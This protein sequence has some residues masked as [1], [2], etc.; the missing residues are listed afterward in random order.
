M[1]QRGRIGLFIFVSG[2]LKQDY[3][4]TP[5]LKLAAMGTT[6]FHHIARVEKTA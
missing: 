4:G 6:T 5:D 1:S 3:V 2:Y